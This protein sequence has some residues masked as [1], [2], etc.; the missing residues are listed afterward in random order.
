M[1]IQ[2]NREF[3]FKGIKIPSVYVRVGFRVPMDS[4]R[5]IVDLYFFADKGAYRTGEVNALYSDDIAPYSTI[6]LNY[7]S[8]RDGTDILPFI[9]QKVLH[10]LTEHESFDDNGNEVITRKKLCDSSEFD[11]VDLPP[12]PF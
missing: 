4:S 10:M 1:A 11:V 12:T 8:N 2:I 3:S 9:H 5:I 7:D 6:E